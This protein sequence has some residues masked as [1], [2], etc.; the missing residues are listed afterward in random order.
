MWHLVGSFLSYINDAR[1]HEPK[2]VDTV[3]LSPTLSINSTFS[4][5]LLP[6]SC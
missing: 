1:S 3:W 4:L 5:L 2:L 6:L